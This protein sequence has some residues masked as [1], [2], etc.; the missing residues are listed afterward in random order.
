MRGRTRVTPGADQPSADRVDARTGTW[1][2][3]EL[4]DVQLGDARLNARL[5]QTVHAL[6]SQ[7]E[8]SVPVACGSWAATKG[9]Y[10][11]W[12]SA[13]VSA[14]AIRA[15]HRRRTVER[16]LLYRTVLV[17]QDTTTLDFSTHHATRGLGPLAGPDL[18]N[19]YGL[20]VHSSMCISPD[21][22]PLGLVDQQMWARDRTR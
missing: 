1:A 8:A 18:S 5:R 17:V 2:D 15:A 22:V 19:L 6:A 21:G 4:H 12:A 11:F 14:T 16:T 9:A 20:Y 10:R 3:A 13:R 7:P